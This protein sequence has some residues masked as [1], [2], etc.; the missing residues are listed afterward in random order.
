MSVQLFLESILTSS[1]SQ[2]LNF[3]T[4]YVLISRIDQIRFSLSPGFGPAV[5]EEH[6]LNPPDPFLMTLE[7]QLP[8]PPLL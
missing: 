8:P 1:S 3:D 6:T 7:H 5:L 4:S 2:R